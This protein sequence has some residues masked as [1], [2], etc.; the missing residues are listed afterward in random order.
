MTDRARMHSFFLDLTRPDSS[1]IAS[2]MEAFEASFQTDMTFQIVSSG[3][4]L[5][6]RLDDFFSVAFRQ[7]PVFPSTE[8]HGY[9]PFAH[10]GPLM[11]PHSLQDPNA[12]SRAPK[13][14][15]N[16]AATTVSVGATGNAV[17]DGTLSG[18]RWDETTISY[19]D[20]DS[21]SDYPSDYTV[22]EDGDGV[23]AQFQDFSQ[24]TDAQRLALHAVLDT[25]VYSQLAGA[26]GL[27]VEGF[28]GLEINYAGPG[29]SDATIRAANSGDAATAYAFYPHAHSAGGDT[30]FGN[31]YDGTINSFKNPVA[32]NYAWHGVLHELG[33]SLGLKHGH[34]AGG[35]G[36]IAL[37]AAYN[38]LEFSAMTYPSFI[39]DTTDG[40][41]YE[42]SGAPQTFMM[43]DILALQTMYGADF[44]ANAGNSVYTWNPST[45]DFYI[46]GLLA[47][48]PVSNRIFSTIWDGN[49]LDTYDLSN[50]TTAMRINLKPGAS[51]TFSAAQLA[52][53]GGGPNDGF[54]RGNVFNAFQFEG[55]PRSLIENANGGSAGDSISGNVAA[56]LLRG[57][58]GNDKLWGLAANDRLFGGNGDDLLI[59]GTG[60]D[61]LDGGVGRDTVSYTQASTGVTASLAKVALNT[62]EAEGDTY[63]AVENLTGSSYSDCLCGNSGANSINGGL[64]ND[65]ISGAAGN[66][67]LSGAAGADAFLF[68]TALNKTDNVDRITDFSVPN[69]TIRLENAIFTALGSA[70]ALTAAG[71]RA[72]TSGLAADVSDRIIYETDAGRLF[73]DFNG[74]ESG[75]RT[76]IAS[77]SSGLN[78]THL[79][80]IVV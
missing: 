80:F 78:I 43:V 76:Q 13:A 5:D 61:T 24:L 28:T 62:G 67:I 64:G 33:H 60:A 42:P 2:L 58:G 19:S 63:Q 25:T 35:P 29:A 8:V 36:D 10:S 59:G 73:Y 71:F 68:N 9:Q 38:S 6:G 1:P 46:D 27:S 74:N 55:D 31:T 45:G 41:D 51:S 56:N 12:A 75:G 39:G 53:L 54:A 66:D 11:E 52:Y 47:L 17:I 57:N 23:S 44:T 40:Y 16:G 3:F 77:L 32:G 30:F 4:P 79:D 20:T 22:D 18:T 65:L 21:S 72:N 15:G 34:E 26:A 7:T 70:G 48:E 50:Y 14:N 49:G 69:D 37:P